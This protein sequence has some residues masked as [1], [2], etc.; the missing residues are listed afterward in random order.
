VAVIKYE[1]SLTFD[2]MNL[3]FQC[4][5]MF[6]RSCAYVKMDEID[7][8]LEDLD[9]ALKINPEYAKAICKKG[10]IYMGLEKYEEAGRLYN[11]AGE[12][13]P[14]YP[15]LGEKIKTAKLELKK[16]KR[17]D[18]YKMLGVT[19]TADFREIKKGYRL[20]AIKWHP[21]KHS[22][23]TEAEK[24]EAEKMFKEIGEAYSI[25]S[26][27]KKRDMFDAGQ[28]IEDINQG[29]RGGGGGQ[30]VFQHFFSGGGG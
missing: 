11:Q 15:G 27:A 19:K 8:A 2:P 10:D 3:E 17:K 26:D 24:L 13:N 7:K 21:D 9:L 4:T 28:D 18:L 1:E 30:D 14:Q 5:I 23:G 25:L 29:G 22:A 20:M 6:N 12:V 16:S